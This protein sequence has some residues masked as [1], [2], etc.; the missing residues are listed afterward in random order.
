MRPSPVGEGRTRNGARSA[1]D[2]EPEPERD[3]H[4]VLG[5][6]QVTQIGIFHLGAVDVVLGGHVEA[7]RAAEAV[8]GD[9]KADLIAFT[10]GANRRVFVGISQ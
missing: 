8:T 4:V 10:R 3:L 6:A 2:R 7:E 1:T 9:N 5:L